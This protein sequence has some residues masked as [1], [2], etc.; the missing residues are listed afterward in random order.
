[1]GRK[2][3]NFEPY[4]EQITAWFHAGFTTEKIRQEMFR[5]YHWKPSLRTLNR[6]LRK[7]GLQKQHRVRVQGGA[8]DELKEQLLILYFQTHAYDSKLSELMRRKGFQ[9][10]TGQIREIRYELGLKHRKATPEE[11]QQQIDEIRITMAKEFAE[12]GRLAELGRGYVHDGVLDSKGNRFPRKK[13]ME[14]YHEFFPSALQRRTWQA[15]REKGEF[16]VYGPNQIWCIDGHDKL[17]RWGIYVYAAVDGY[18]RYITWFHVAWFGGT[19]ISTLIQY[20]QVVRE[21]GWVPRTVRADRGKEVPLLAAAHWA[22]VREAYSNQ[23]GSSVEFG[24]CF[25]YGRS[26]DNTRIEAWWAQVQ[27]SCLTRWGVVFARMEH[28]RL[29]ICDKLA[30]E[31]ALLAVYVPVMR[32]E[33]EIFV[34]RWNKHSI[35]GQPNRANSVRGR[36]WENYFVPNPDYV[37]QWGL[38]VDTELLAGIEAVLSTEDIGEY[39]PE[40]TRIWC[41]AF[42]TRVGLDRSKEDKHDMPFVD[43]YNQLRTAIQIELDNGNHHGLSLALTPTSGGLAELQRRLAELKNFPSRQDYEDAVRKG[44]IQNEN[45]EEVFDFSNAAPHADITV[46][47]EREDDNIIDVGDWRYIKP[48][49]SSAE[50]SSD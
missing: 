39:L 41:E 34:H 17:K 10:S 29:W 36:P 48:E 49:N 21:L 24:D 11:K 47:D 33:I 20:L 43:Y 9:V 8:F 18:S 28:E 4:K 15:R 2:S 42:L 25:Y 40:A 7:W 37:S 14:V 22:F 13:L 1:M 12:S 27:K 23:D 3:I 35:R 44:D 19:S 45:Q 46:K 32:K 38:R 31:I 16:I 5:K 30:C 26:M 50:E 6:T